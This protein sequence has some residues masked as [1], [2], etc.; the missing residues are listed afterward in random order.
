MAAE[1]LDSREPASRL[2]SPEPE[3]GKCCFSGIRNNSKLAFTAESFC[4]KFF[5]FDSGSAELSSQP[6]QQPNGFLTKPLI[7]RAGRTISL[8]QENIKKRNKT[9]KLWYHNISQL[10][11]EVR[12]LVGFRLVFCFLYCSR[13][14]HSSFNYSSDG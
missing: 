6:H 2:A 12:L 11:T 14:V 10:F 13:E 7:C 8:S 1:W 3:S 5:F 4:K 9:T